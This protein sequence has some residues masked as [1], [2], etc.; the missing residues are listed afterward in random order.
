M[1]TERKTGNGTAKTIDL[2]DQLPAEIRQLISD[3]AGKPIL[4]IATDLHSSDISEI[5]NHL[6]ADDGAFI[7]HLL[8]PETAAE[9]P[10]ELDGGA[11]S[12][13]LDI[14]VVNEGN[15]LVG[16][17]TIFLGLATHLLHRIV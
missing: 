6:S 14:T 16:T 15:R 3:G 8:R 10:P 17:I 11:R 5:L 13:L 9:V 2:D 1:Y 12:G 4:N 7:L